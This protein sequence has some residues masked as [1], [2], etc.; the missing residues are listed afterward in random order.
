MSRIWLDDNEIFRRQQAAQ[1]LT[2]CVA[3]VIAAA[4]WFWHCMRRDEQARFNVNAQAVLDDA[5]RIV[6]IEQHR[7]NHPT[8]RGDR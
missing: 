6:R 5:E 3:T 4:V 1:W 2:A 8:A 7:M